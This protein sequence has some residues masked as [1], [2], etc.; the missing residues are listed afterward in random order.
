MNIEK[1]TQKAQSILSSAQ[2]NALAFGHQKLFPLHLLNSIAEDDD[3][4]GQKIIQLC[5]GNFAIL[6]KKRKYKLN[7]RK[8]VHCNVCFVLVLFSGGDR[9][10]IQDS[11]NITQ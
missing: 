5:D 6:Q 2:T 9:H 8:E 3:N 1:Y 10:F 11:C 7:K 4:L